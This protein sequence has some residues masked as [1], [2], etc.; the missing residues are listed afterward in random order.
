MRLIAILP[1]LLLAL[2]GGISHAT[3]AQSSA[4]GEVNWICEQAFAE[5]ILDTATVGDETRLDKAVRSCSSLDDWLLAAAIHP[6]A[7]G[8]VDPRAF[9]DSRCRDV[10]ASLADYATL[11]G[12]AVDDGEVTQVRWSN[13]RGWSGLAP[14]RPSTGHACHGAGVDARRKRD[15]ILHAYVR[16]AA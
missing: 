8:D 7:T 13:D 4:T 5:A 11:A 16:S 6:G 10:S 15:R 14:V 12:I 3:A 1:W 2:T 9:L